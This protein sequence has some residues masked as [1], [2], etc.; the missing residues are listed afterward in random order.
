M[1]QKSEVFFFLSGEEEMYSDRNLSE[2]LFK[3]NFFFFWQ[4]E[5]TKI[6]LKKM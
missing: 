3:K 6:N 1:K 2:A 4:D 5:I